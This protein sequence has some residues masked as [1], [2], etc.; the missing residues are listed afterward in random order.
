MNFWLTDD[1]YVKKINGKPH[2]IRVR[3]PSKSASEDAAPSTNY[4]TSRS[5]SRSNSS[6]QRA[7]VA[8]V[9]EVELIEKAKFTELK[10][11]FDKLAELLK[12]SPRG[13]PQNQPSSFNINKETKNMAGDDKKEAAKGDASNKSTGTENVTSNVPPAGSMLP[14]GFQ[15][16]PGIYTVGGR[17][18]ALVPAPAKSNT[19]FV[20]PNGYAPPGLGQ[21]Y[22]YGGGRGPMMGGMMGGMMQ[23]PQPQMGMGFG[24]FNSQ[25]DRPQPVEVTQVNPA[26]NPATNT[27]T[28]HVCAGCGTLRSRKFQAENPLGPGEVP[29]ISYCR[30]CQKEET[31]SESSD[32]KP[33]K[34]TVSVE[35]RSTD[36]RQCVA[37]PTV[38]ERRVDSVITARQKVSTPSCEVILSRSGRIPVR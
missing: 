14:P 11:N 31:S 2:L 28:R 1:T 23:Q 3:P 15:A 36:R 20:G 34:S 12:A 37:V 29:P 27:I 35:R 13:T 30:K 24:G 22:M 38:D 16:A 5:Q 8:K 17:T 10:E 33:Q 9:E 4:T 6:A 18:L 25:Y 19:G 21:Q 26:T 32:V 7:S